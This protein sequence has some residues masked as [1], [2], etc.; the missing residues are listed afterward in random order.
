MQ[1]QRKWLQFGQDLNKAHLPIQVAFQAFNYKGSKKG[2]VSLGIGKTEAKV[3]ITQEVEAVWGS[4]AF[5]QQGGK[6]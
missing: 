3:G 2:V 1:R 6:R 5:F 4:L